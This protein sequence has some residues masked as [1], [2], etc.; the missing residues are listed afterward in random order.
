MFFLPLA[1]VSRAGVARGLSALE[2]GVE[3]SSTGLDSL[4]QALI[5]PTTTQQVYL[6]HLLRIMLILICI[7]CPYLRSKD[8]PAPIPEQF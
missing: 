1:V 4:P 2:T 5:K 3:R 6:F 7:F 8:Q